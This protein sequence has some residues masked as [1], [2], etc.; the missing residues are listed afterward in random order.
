ML[1]A[2]PCVVATWKLVRVSV[3]ELWMW[4]AD[5]K[6][7][8]WRTQTEWVSTQNSNMSILSCP[9]N[10]KE[11]AGMLQ[12]PISKLEFSWKFK[13]SF[14]PSVMRQASLTQVWFSLVSMMLF[15]PSIMHQMSSIT[16][17]HDARL[18]YR[19]ILA[20]CV[21]FLDANAWCKWA[22]SIHGKNM[23]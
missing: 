9:Y 5:S 1:I 2:H 13:G 10:G 3:T 19:P 7:P 16:R 17:Q 12:Y 15:T 21:K 11:Y 22:P 6:T 18:G 8:V 20:S 23:Q 4:R 14:T